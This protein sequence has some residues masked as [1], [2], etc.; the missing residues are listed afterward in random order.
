MEQV[1]SDKGSGLPEVWQTY[2]TVIKTAVGTEV[3][4]VFA[5]FVSYCTRNILNP[6]LVWPFNS[7]TKHIEYVHLSI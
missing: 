7:I 4:G 1:S 2:Q 3:T 6:R 5:L